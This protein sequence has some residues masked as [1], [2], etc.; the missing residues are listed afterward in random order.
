M[1]I[2]TKAGAMGCV[3]YKGWNEKGELEYYHKHNFPIEH[4]TVC[5]LYYDTWA[6]RIGGGAD[7]LIAYCHCGTGNGQ[8]AASTNLATPLAENR[9]IFDSATQGAGADAHKVVIVTTFGAGVCTGNLEEAGLF[10]TQPHGN[11]D[12]QLYDDTLSYVK[13]AGSTL[14]ITWTIIHSN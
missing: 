7:T 6:D 1:N 3:E 13:N 14:E 5:D 4:N 8:G 10:P 2:N 11:A 12:M 9:T